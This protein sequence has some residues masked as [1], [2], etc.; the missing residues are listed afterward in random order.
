VLCRPLILSRFGTWTH[1]SG[2]V[3][4]RFGPVLRYPVLAISHLGA[5]L[6]ASQ[7]RRLADADERL[8]QLIPA[9]RRIGSL[10]ARDL[11]EARTSLAPMRPLD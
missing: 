10:L 2:L 11:R 7:R 9:L 8:A 3:I 5:D 1:R 4:K 6:S